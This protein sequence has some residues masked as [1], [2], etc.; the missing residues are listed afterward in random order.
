MKVN[1]SGSG[2]RFAHNGDFQPGDLVDIKMVFPTAPFSIIKAIGLV[3]RSD[4]PLM[5][6]S[7]RIVPSKYTAA[8]FIA[9]HE[10]SKEAII[11]CV[12]TW[13]RQ[14]LRENRPRGTVEI[15]S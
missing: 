11:R 8:K 10:Q 5:A 1:V 3:V 13:Q 6:D 15:F 9:M 7:G 12:F 2:I 14:L 4:E